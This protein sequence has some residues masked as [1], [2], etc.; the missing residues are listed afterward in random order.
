LW[1]SEAPTD[2]VYLPFSQNPQANMALM[3]QSR[4]FDASAVVAPL[5]E[6]VRSLD[7]NMPIFEVRTMRSLYESR[8]VATPNLITETVAGL[9]VMGFVLSVIG[10]YGVVS[11]GVSRRVREFGIRMAVG[12][13]RLSIVRMVVGQGMAPAVAGLAV[14]LVVGILAV[15]VVTSSLLFSFGFGVL[16]FVVVSLLLLAVTALAAY[17]PARRASLVEPMKALRDE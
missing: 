6:A 2:F 9:G 15:R 4:S 16:P 3:A 1:I 11:Y 7:P 10:L 8:A 17:A 12:A 5:K 14:G 13:D